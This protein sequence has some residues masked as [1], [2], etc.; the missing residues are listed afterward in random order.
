V[1]VFWGVAPYTPVSFCQTT[2]SSIP[3][4]RN[5]YIRRRENLTPHLAEKKLLATVHELN[6]YAMDEAGHRLRATD[7][8]K[9]AVQIRLT[10]NL[11]TV[12]VRILDPSGLCGRRVL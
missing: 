1:V 7:N 6:I 3:E 9:T 4:E 12:V 11:Q 8:I 2:R 10:W 5:L